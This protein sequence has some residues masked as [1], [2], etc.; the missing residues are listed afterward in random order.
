MRYVVLLSMILALGPGCAIVFDGDGSGDDVC[1]AA[2]EPAALP[3][4]LRNPDTLTCD[5]F[6]GGGC[7]PECGPCPAV[8]VDLAPIPTW[9]VCNGACDALSEAACAAEPGCRVVKDA[10][11]A[12]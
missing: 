2:P 11:C 12:V 5:S 10:A 7:V 4:P 1:L 8:A 6:G 9:G 3:A